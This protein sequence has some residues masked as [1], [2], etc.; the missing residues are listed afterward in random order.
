VEHRTASVAI[1]PPSEQE[2][3]QAQPRGRFD[4][5]QATEDQP[6]GDTAAP[7]RAAAGGDKL[8]QARSPLAPLPSVQPIRPTPTDRAPI[9]PGDVDDGQRLERD[10]HDGVQNELVALIFKLARAHQDP[11]TPAQLAHTLAELEAHAQ[12]ALDSVRRIAQGN[13]P[14]LLAGFGLRAALRAQAARVSIGPRLVG[15]APRS[16]EQAEQAAYFSCSEAIQNAAK[17]AGV[18]AHV[19]VRLDHH[20][21]T[22]LVRVADDGQGFEPVRTSEGAG[23]RNIRDRIDGLGGSFKVASQPGLGTL[24][25]IS[26]P[27]PAAPDGR[28]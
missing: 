7:I 11:E 12:A 10:L 13:Y 23:L 5:R 2:A 9:A 6:S 4:R 18:T 22:L 1:R 15:T 16:T 21:R 14:P 26:L 3:P 20:D 19:T 25:T 24:L 8:P 27:W 17:H 28:R